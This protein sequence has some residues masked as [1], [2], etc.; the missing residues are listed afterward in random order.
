MKKTALVI[1]LA[2]FLFLLSF[3]AY[4]WKIT[5]E[6]ESEIK[7][8][9][10]VL[11]ENP[12]DPYASFELAITYAYTN[13]IQEGWDTLKKLNEKYPQFKNQAYKTYTKK[14]IESP[15]DW[16]LRFRL[17]FAL[18]FADKKQDAIKELKNVLL[19]D[20]NNVWAYGYI[21]LIYG[22]TGEIDKAIEY[23]KAGIKKDNLVA[24]LHL[25]LSQGYYQ[26]GDSWG[27]FW[28]ATTAIR[29]KAQGY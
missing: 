21:S 19:L 4:A 22:E 23:A 9:K 17:A 20:P 14:V 11:K 5:K 7:A 15:N 6:L 16:R 26:K 25:L 28:E 1:I 2:V 13:Y 18:Y 27:G 29:L 12:D 3:E 24:A 8:K 10:E